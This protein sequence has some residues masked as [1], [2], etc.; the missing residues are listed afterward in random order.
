MKNVRSITPNDTAD[1]TPELGDYK[2]LQPFR[3]WCHKVLPLVYDDSLSYYELLCKVVDYL[4]KT[5]EDVETLHGDVT[6]LHKAYEKLQ[7][8][9]NNYFSS[10]DVQEEIN[11][12]LDNM[13]KSGELYAIIRRY[14]DPIVNEQNE[15]ID[16]LKSRMDTFAR[17]PNGSTTGDA[18]LQDI[19]VGYNGVKYSSA[20]NAVRGQVSELNDYFSK[21]ELVKGN[22]F[23]KNNYT[24]V[25]MYNSSNKFVAN[26]ASLAFIIPIVGGKDYTIHCNATSRNRN[27]IVITDSIPENGSSYATEKYYSLVGDISIKTESS[28]KYVYAWFYY[29]NITNAI[30]ADI[31]SNIVI[32]EGSSY[33]STPSDYMAITEYGLSGSVADYCENTINDRY[34]KNNYF[35]YSNI[36]IVNLYNSNGKFVEDS[37]AYAICV[38]I[39]GGYRYKIHRGDSS[40][41]RNNII[42]TDRLPFKG[43]SYTSTKVISDTSEDIYI[44]TDKADKYIYLWLYFGVISTDIQNDIVTNLVV[45]KY[46]EKTSIT[47]LKGVFFGDSFTAGDK[48]YHYWIG[49]RTDCV[50]YNY[51]VGGSAITPTTDEYSDDFL[52]RIPAL[53]TAHI[54]FL[55]I[56]GGINDSWVLSTNRRQL[57]TIDDVYSDNHITCYGAFNKLCEDLIAKY[58][59]TPILALLPPNII[60]NNLSYAHAENINTVCEALKNVYTKYGIPFLDM[61]SESGISTLEPHKKLYNNKSTSTDDG[62][63]MH[64]NNKAHEKISHI[65]Q[66]FIEEH[67]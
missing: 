66:K 1:F 8:Y 37:S 2:T 32:V 56:F 36:N 22:Y 44:N 61:R 19:R 14:T 6:N 41:N 23:D 26:E 9:V 12:K 39:I 20:G 40:R 21:F 17:L 24:I 27:N 3:Y 28:D 29:G 42:I 11:N 48:R 53:P 33:T 5:M 51:G 34:L 49:K 60:N 50:C 35:N 31:V 43:M 7:S 52:K 25:N 10:L 16:V 67:I 54:D 62:Y 46:E 38:P 13:A 15:K 45:S 30:I 55:V 58:P 65:I 64:W 4:N 57:G 63:D 59:N 18:E 47:N